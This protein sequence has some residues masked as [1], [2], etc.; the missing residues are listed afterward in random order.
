[1]GWA[2]GGAFGIEASLAT[3]IVL[4]VIIA[5]LLF[6]P[7]PKKKEAPAEVQA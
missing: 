6:V 3:T 1:M 5:A 2:N 4:G 7:S